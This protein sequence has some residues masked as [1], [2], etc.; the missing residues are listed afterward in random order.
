MTSNGKCVK[1]NA[2]FSL[3]EMLVV[4]T[5]LVVLSMIGTNLFLGTLTGSNKTSIGLSLKQ[6]GEYAMTQMINMIRGATRIETCAVSEI[7]IRNPDDQTTQ[8]TLEDNRI[9]S[10][11][12]FYLT[13]NDVYVTQGP[14]F[15]CTLENGVYTF[16][17]ISF[18]LK[19][20]DPQ[21]DKPIDVVE[22]SFTG[23]VGVRKY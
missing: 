22:Q 19:K 15:T 5:L 3:I 9:A 12:G 10:N 7:T 1:L 20:G 14:S 17:N 16:A 11:S 6:Q 23:G 2:G 18:T 21:V 8:F 4:I 13:G